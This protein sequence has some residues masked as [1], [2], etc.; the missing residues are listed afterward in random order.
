MK[1]RLFTVVI[2]GFTLSN[3]GFSINNGFDILRGDANNDGQVNI[4]DSIA[5]NNW[6][7][8]GG[9]Q[10]PCMDAADVND[11]GRVDVSDSAYLNTF[12]FQG[13]PPPAPPYPNCG[14]DPTFDYLTCSS[15]ACH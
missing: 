9:S 14:Q 4:S 13:G 2:I 5:I 8:N 12:L 10:P 6:L 3:T 1:I 7:F 15:S 11:D